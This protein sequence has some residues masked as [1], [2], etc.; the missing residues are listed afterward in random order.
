[1]EGDTTEKPGGEET[2]P[3]AGGGTRD[4]FLPIASW[5]MYDFANTIYSGIVV[6]FFLSIYLT[7][8][9]GLPAT[10]FGVT[11]TLSLIAA[12]LISPF[13]GSIPDFTGKTKRYCLLATF[14]CVACTSAL[15][16]LPTALFLLAAYF[17]A[18][19]TYQVG[20]VFYNALLPTVASPRLQGFVSGWGVALGYIGVILALLVAKQFIVC[21]EQGDP[22]GELRS[23]AISGTN[24]ENSDE[25]QL[26]AVYEKEETDAGAVYVIRFFR[27]PEREAG[28]LV[29]SAVSAAGASLP[30]TLLIQ[31]TLEEHPIKGSVCLE[32]FSGPNR[33]IEVRKSVRW[34]FLVAG[35]LF[36][37]FTLPLAF[38]VPER[39]VADPKPFRLSLALRGFGE[40]WNTVKSLPSKRNLL[41]FLVG[42]VLCVD[43]LN[44]AINWFSKYFRGVFAFTFGDIIQLGLGI[45]ASAFL[46]GLI[47][48]KITDKFGSKPTMIAAAVS[49][50]VTIFAVGLVSASWLA[51]AVIFSVGALGLAG[52][53]V[54]GRKLL[55]E[56]APPDRI[57]EYFGLHGITIKISVLGTTVFGIIVDTFP[58]AG[59]WNYR[60]AILIQL[61]TLLPGIVFLWLVK[62]KSAPEDPGR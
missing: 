29:A 58:T 15:S 10:T 30:Q 47:M 7:E 42:N 50:A 43:V 51:L 49:L 19:V 21:V 56:L 55:I 41:F 40:V 27:R 32:A 16:S 44:T 8:E 35:A 31:P 13:L 60:F 6:T 14:V 1:M 28:Q 3:P 4:R 25:G 17:L 34:V 36:L 54:A 53:W 22:G 57:G 46:A 39:R 37:L 11:T 33:S 59:N 62:T 52:L 61:A 18:N 2:A 45:S 38:F 9:I 26:Y 12:G 24:T 48:G 23:W 20:M 5:A